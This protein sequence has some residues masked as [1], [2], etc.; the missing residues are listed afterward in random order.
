MNAR[1]RG[2]ASVRL[3]FNGSKLRIFRRRAKLSLSQVSEMTSISTSSLSDYECGLIVPQL[4]QLKKLCEIYELDP[5]EVCEL[6]WL[7]FVDT[8][9]LKSFRA[10]CQQAGHTPLQVYRSLIINYKNWVKKE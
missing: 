4:H 6:L 3:R 1:N 5:I 2:K 9:F 8:S 10:A 7:K